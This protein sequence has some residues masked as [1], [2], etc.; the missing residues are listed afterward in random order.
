M[1]GEKLHK[2]ATPSPVTGGVILKT[3]VPDY[4]V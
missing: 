1:S 3:G 2:E 4:D